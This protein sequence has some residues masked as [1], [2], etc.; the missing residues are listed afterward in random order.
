[1]NI[2]GIRPNAGFYDYNSIKIDELR[3]QQLVYL[4]AP[5]VEAEAPKH[6]VTDQEIA[7]ARSHQTFNAFEYSKQYLAGEIYEMKGRDSD[8]ESLDVQ[9][10]IS[11]MEQDSILKQYQFFVGDRANSS[12]KTVLHSGENFVL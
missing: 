10:A 11:S 7:E 9:K 6:V 8:I 5:V 4:E 12:D 3:R 1:M 2:S